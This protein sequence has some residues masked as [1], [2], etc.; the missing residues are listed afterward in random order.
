MLHFM[1]KLISRQIKDY[2][3]RSGPN[4]V[5]SIYRMILWKLHVTAF[6]YNSYQSIWSALYN[7]MDNIL[8]T[9][10][11]SCVLNIRLHYKP[12]SSCLNLMK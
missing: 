7:L 2:N 3:S 4:A 1:K 9:F 12:P 6:K 10:M 11:T 5:I 8:L